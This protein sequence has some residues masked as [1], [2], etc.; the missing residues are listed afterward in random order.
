[1]K[2]PLVYVAGPIT[3]DPLTHTHD[4]IIVGNQLVND[5]LVCPYLPQLSC[6]WHMVTPQSYDWWLRHDLD[7]IVRCQ[8]LLRRP[9]S[10]KGADAEVAHAQACGIPVFFDI[11]SLYAWAGPAPF[12]GTPYIEDGG[13]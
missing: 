7:V 3:S 5:G 8:A 2:K 13:W 6:F 11:V 9:G 12:T 1:M 4:A 10:S